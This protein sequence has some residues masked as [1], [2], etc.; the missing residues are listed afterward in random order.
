MPWCLDRVLLVIAMSTSALATCASGAGP[1]VPDATNISQRCF[2]LTAE[3]T[4]NAASCFHLC[5]LHSTLA[6]PA[7]LSEASFLGDIFA[8]DGPRWL[9]IYWP[10]EESEPR[11]TSGAN[12]SSTVVGSILGQHNSGDVPSLCSY[13][14]SRPYSYNGYSLWLWR[15][16]CNHNNRCLRCVCEAS[17]TAREAADDLA[18][19][20]AREEALLWEENAAFFTEVLLLAFLPP[21]TCV[22]LFLLHRRSHC[23]A[24]RTSRTGRALLAVRRHV[25]KRSSA[26]E[27]APLGGLVSSSS[28]HTLTDEAPSLNSSFSTGS[29]S[30][31]SSFGSSGSAKEDEDAYAYSSSTGHAASTPS[32]RTD[33]VAPAGRTSVFEA[34][35]LMTDVMP[36]TSKFL[37]ADAALKAASAIVAAPA[38]APTP[39]P[40]P[41]TAPAPA[42]AVQGQVFSHRK[43]LASGGPI[44]RSSL[45]VIGSGA[46]ADGP[47]SAARLH[48]ATFAAAQVRLRVT[49]LCLSLGWACCVW[50]ISLG[51]YWGQRRLPAAL[52]N[53]V[54]QNVVLPPGLVGLML[55]LLPTDRRAV[56]LSAWVL[57][58]FF[59]YY[60]WAKLRAAFLFLTLTEDRDEYHVLRFISD[61][62]ARSYVTAAVY[63]FCAAPVGLLSGLFLIRSLVFW[64][65]R[66]TLQ[67]RPSLHRQWRAVRFFLFAHS[68][69]LGCYIVATLCVFPGYL[70]DSYFHSNVLVVVSYL[71]CSYLSAPKYR[72]RAAAWLGALGTRD[73]A[74]RAAAVAGLIGGHSAQSA[75][76]LAEQRFAAL[77]FSA[78]SFED[79]ACSAD[80]GLHAKTVG[81]ALGRCDAFHS[82]SWSDDAMAKWAKVS[83]WAA[84][85]R[86]SHDGREPLLW[87]DKAC[88][89]QRAIDESL[90]GLP[91]YLAGCE[92]LLITIGKSYPTRLWCCM[93]L[94]TFTSMGGATERV[95]IKRLDLDEAADGFSALTDQLCLTF[96]VT[97]ATCFRV[98]DKQR[99]LAV[100]EAGYG[101]TALFNKEV[102]AVFRRC[103]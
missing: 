64:D 58:L 56:R 13:Q 91:V 102:R 99:L 21:L 45:R 12:V 53:S 27:L 43:Q 75:L 50:A 98:S 36:E 79:Y 89:N 24:K 40:A 52:D 25:L 20:A 14:A 84:A 67:T 55:A 39:A 19:I 4:H 41:A 92:T 65:S 51:G 38:P 44:W 81:V 62:F 74:K 35:G 71:G 88:I 63:Y 66:W 8:G 42:A 10:D 54:T 22:S 46:A 11:C 85:F 95:V 28:T 33:Y 3:C 49:G 32:T 5:G 68:I 101:D 57:L 37:E 6:C 1:A 100:I 83:E 77:P 47:Q 29:C 94:F 34:A 69:L 80:T 93:E 76:R 23:R 15:Y 61:S 72:Q 60:T 26:V 82:H 86:Q 103:L 2:T 87:L 9:G 31:N 59:G 78:L 17:E 16:R 18:Q 30:F 7:S 97:E 73:E 96:D 48:S 70:H 90:A